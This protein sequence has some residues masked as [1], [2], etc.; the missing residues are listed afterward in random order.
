VLTVWGLK[1]DWETAALVFGIA[2]LTTGCG[3]L[4]P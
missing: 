4:H 1:R 3:M 2:C